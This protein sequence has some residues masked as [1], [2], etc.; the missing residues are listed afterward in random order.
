MLAACRDDG[1][2]PRHERGERTHHTLRRIAHAEH[3]SERRHERRDAPA[4]VVDHDRFEA[5]PD[6]LDR[7]LSYGLREDR[8]E[9]FGV[10]RRRVDVDRVV[11]AR[12]AG[13][14]LA[15]DAF[16]FRDAIAAV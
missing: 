15:A 2:K 1:W 3:F 7:A 16:G 12:I 9:D 13:L 10:D 14:V 8:V 11:E 6:E 5:E 4:V